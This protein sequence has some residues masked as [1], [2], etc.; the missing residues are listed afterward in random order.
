MDGEDV[1]YCLMML[2]IIDKGIGSFSNERS[3]REGRKLCIPSWQPLSIT[4]VK[5]KKAMDFIWQC[6]FIWIFQL[7]CVYNVL[8]RGHFPPKKDVYQKQR[9]HG[10]KN[11]QGFAPRT[12]ENSVTKLPGTR[13][14]NLNFHLF[15]GENDPSGIT[16]EDSVLP[17]LNTA[18]RLSYCR[19]RNTV[20]EVQYWG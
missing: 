1:R 13:P 2:E 19:M 18:K 10:L 14:G 15:C 12:S 9:G 16:K 4:H 3:Q 7:G 17:I 8:K 5:Q 6:H 11:S 20:T